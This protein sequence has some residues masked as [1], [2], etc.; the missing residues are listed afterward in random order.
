MSVILFGFGLACK[1]E[2]SHIKDVRLQN[3]H[4]VV[5][6]RYFLANAGR[7]L[8][9]SQYERFRRLCSMSFVEHDVLHVTCLCEALSHGAK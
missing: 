8:R 7:H 5:L 2:V 9:R 3:E 6:H 1:V 4:I